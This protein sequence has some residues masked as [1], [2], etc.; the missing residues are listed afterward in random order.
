MEQDKQDKYTFTVVKAEYSY[1]EIDV[2]SDNIENAHNE[3]MLKAEKESF[4]EPIEKDY[5]VKTIIKNG[6]P[7]IY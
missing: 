4:P 6:R 2:L 7:L 1:V 5:S 3:A